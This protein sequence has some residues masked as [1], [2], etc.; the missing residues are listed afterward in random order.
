MYSG[1]FALIRNGRKTESPNKD[2]P[3]DFVE[4]MVCD[5]VLPVS[6]RAGVKG[7]PIAVHISIYHLEGSEGIRVVDGPSKRQ[8]KLQLL[9]YFRKV[10]ENATLMRAS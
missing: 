2:K 9:R 7:T 5:G 4:E 1:S 3:I 10:H 6:F 8:L